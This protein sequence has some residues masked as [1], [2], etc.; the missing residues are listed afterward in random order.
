MKSILKELYKNSR[1][2]KIIK[3][4]FDSF[5]EGSYI[6]YEIAN[7]IKC[8]VSILLR[9]SK[10]SDFSVRQR[11]AWNRNTPIEALL[12]LSK[13]YD[14]QTRVWATK[15]PTYIKYKKENGL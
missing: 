3:L 8:P 1:F 5:S 12:E 7:D 4:I 11:T 6:R 10:D 15:N 13:D 2:T 9:L 14:Y